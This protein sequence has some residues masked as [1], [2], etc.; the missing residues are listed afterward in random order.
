MMRPAYQRKSA[1]RALSQLG[2]R[3]KPCLYEENRLVSG[4]PH[5]SKRLGNTA[6]VHYAISQSKSLG[7]ITASTSP[8]WVVHR[9]KG[10]SD[11]KITTDAVE[12][13]RFNKSSFVGS[14]SSLAN[15]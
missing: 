13:P 15:H 3:Y 4:M 2:C 14:D 9:L 7:L 10:V 8:S 12:S 1:I 11:P 5:V 6:N